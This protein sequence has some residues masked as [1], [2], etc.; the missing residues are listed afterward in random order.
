MLVV[1][2]L[3]GF[4]IV[5]QL[6][7]M[8]PEIKQR[9]IPTQTL[10][11]KELCMSIKI[12]CSQFSS[13]FTIARLTYNQPNFR[14]NSALLAHETRCRTFAMYIS[15]LRVLFFLLLR[16]LTYLEIKSQRNR[17]SNTMRPLNGVCAF[18]AYRAHAHICASV[19]IFSVSLE[20][21]TPTALRQGR[22][23]RASG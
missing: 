22:S 21:N 4:A 15:F 7:R 9:M 13:Q 8:S 14:V 19:G 20:M 23:V 11:K 2:Q 10:Y 6:Q 5:C 17:L 16:P 1:M 3:I 12:V 18:T